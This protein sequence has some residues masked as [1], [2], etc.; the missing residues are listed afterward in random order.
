MTTVR[1]GEALRGRE[2]WLPSYDAHLGIREL[3]RALMLP[4]QATYSIA[5]NRRTE[6]LLAQRLTF[7]RSQAG[8]CGITDK[9]RICV[10]PDQTPPE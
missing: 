2:K 1:L 8:P 9:L 3:Y 5:K 7:P 4:V 6:R 10:P